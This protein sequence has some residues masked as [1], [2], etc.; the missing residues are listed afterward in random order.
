MTDSIY[1]F[2]DY[3]LIMLII[4]I[5]A[6]IAAAGVIIYDRI[7]TKHTFDSI[8]SM[9]D[10]AIDGTFSESR[11]DETEMSALESKLWKLQNN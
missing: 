5:I 7:K 2:A 10:S 4:G 1:I 8:N 3:G 6:V 11:F 9:L